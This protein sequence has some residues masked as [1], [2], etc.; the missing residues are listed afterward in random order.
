MDEALHIHFSPVLGQGFAPLVQVDAA[1]EIEKALFAI[2]I[3]L[4]CLTLTFNLIADYVSHKF[5]QTG[6]GTL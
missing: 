3:V 1:I 2:G 6:S 5:H 4:F